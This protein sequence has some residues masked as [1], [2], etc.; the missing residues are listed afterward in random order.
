MLYLSVL[1]IIMEYVFALLFVLSGPL[2][3]IGLIWPNFLQSLYGR[4]LTRGQNVLI[5]FL[6]GFVSLLGFGFTAT[7]SES[8]TALSLNKVS[9]ESYEGKVASDDQPA[10]EIL[11]VNASL[12]EIIDVEKNLKSEVVNSEA[13]L[14]TKVIDGDTIDVLIGGETKRVRYIGIDTPETVHPSKPVECF[15]FEAS[16]KNKELVAGKMVQLVKDIS[17]TDKYGRLLRYV[18]VDGVFVNLALVEGGYANVYSY[19][20]DVA[21]IDLF[22][23]AERKARASSVGLWGDVCK[24]SDME[25]S[26]IVV[27]TSEADST[28][29][30]PDSQCVIKGNING[31]GEKIFHAPGCQSYNQTKINEEAGEEWFCSEREALDAGWRKALN[32]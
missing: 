22:L 15:G 27:P 5:Y 9:E 19:P 21:K 20:P 4:T 11:E 30:S 24:E 3:L 32:C 12:S 8:T 31:S 7:V 16:N 1:L 25:A 26:S 18:Y 29:T 10:S 2:L 17:E 6:L 14:V 23:E 28:V 13:Y